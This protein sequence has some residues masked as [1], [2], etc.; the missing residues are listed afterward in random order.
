MNN[1]TKIWLG[2]GVYLLMNVAPASALSSGNE[3]VS[4]N[5]EG[6]SFLNSEVQDK[7]VYVVSKGDEGGEGDEDK[8]EGGE[9]GEG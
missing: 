4:A 6:Q 3:E 9:G 1:Q 5:F 2:V 8:D 7:N